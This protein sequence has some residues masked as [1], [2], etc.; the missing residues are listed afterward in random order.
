MRVTTIQVSSSMDQCTETLPQENG[1]V[2]KSRTCII[3]QN[4]K[5]T[6]ERHLGDLM[7]TGVLS[8]PWHRVPGVSFKHLFSLYFR[9]IVL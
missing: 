1:R 8:I 5:F 2:N 7:L 4:G 3:G 9:S 6:D